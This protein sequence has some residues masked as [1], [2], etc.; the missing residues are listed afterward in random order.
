M[1][2][3]LLDSKAY[4]RAILDALPSSVLV[5][6]QDLMIHDANRSAFELLGK[7]PE[8]ILSRLC[9][10]ILNCIHARQSSG[11][12]GTT[13]YCPKCV[14]RQT[15][16]A[17][18]HG[19]NIFRRTGEMKLEEDEQVREI[20]F[21][22]TGVPFDYA[23]MN[24]VLLVIEDITELVQLRRIIPICAHCRKVRNDSEYWYHVEDYL[25]Q[26]TNVQF[27]HGVCPDCLKT[28]YTDLLDKNNEKADKSE[29]KKK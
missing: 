15:V 2:K 20:H 7:R 5:M 9:G 3:R 13:D 24:L 27:S 26:H 12:C 29:K 25:K 17:V 22:V 10:D 16:E 18:V 4:V 11:G 28:H 6:D 23:D 8:K 14:I 19:K 21:I 1:A